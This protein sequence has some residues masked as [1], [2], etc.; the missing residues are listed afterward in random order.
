MGECLSV[1]MHL[2]L[3]CNALVGAGARLCCLSMCLHIHAICM[4]IAL[5]ELAYAIVC[6]RRRG[7]CER[8]PSTNGAGRREKVLCERVR[9]CTCACACA[10]AR[11]RARVRVRVRVRVCA[12]VRER[13][14]VCVRNCVRVRVRACARPCACVWRGRAPASVATPV[15][16]PS[17]PPSG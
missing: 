1:G 12:C 15:R 6:A 16:Q 5:R 10:R 11:A 3:C 7:Q 8:G 9:A 14:R 4:C 13:V 17:S 2:N